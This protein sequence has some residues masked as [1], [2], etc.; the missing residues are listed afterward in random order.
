MALIDRIK[1]YRNEKW[2]ERTLLCFA[3][4]YVGEEARSMG[5]TYTSAE[6]GEIFGAILGYDLERSETTVAGTAKDQDR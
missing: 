6:V 4:G 2:D 5:R 1:H 3:L